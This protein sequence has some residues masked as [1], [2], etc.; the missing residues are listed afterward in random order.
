MRNQRNYNFTVPMAYCTFHSDNFC[1]SRTVTLIVTVLVPQALFLAYGRAIFL[2]V[3]WG[4]RSQA[5]LSLVCGLQVL[6]VTNNT[7]CAKL[8][9]EIKCAHCSPHA[10]NLFHSPEKGETPE[11]ELML[12]Y[13]CKDYCK[14]FYYTCR[15]HI[16]GKT[17]N[18]GL[19]DVL[20]C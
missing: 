15:G 8:L 7:E 2:C 11:K 12:P 14:E 19:Q 16:P 18:M 6:S 13:L 9:E 17:Q 3:R 1:S 10:Q 20:M 5:Y 4:H